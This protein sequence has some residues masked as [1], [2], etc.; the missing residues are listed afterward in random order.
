MNRRIILKC[1]IQKECEYVDL[2]KL[3]VIQIPYDLNTIL[4]VHILGVELYR[5]S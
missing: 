1:I 3:V 2:I 4:Y 5:F